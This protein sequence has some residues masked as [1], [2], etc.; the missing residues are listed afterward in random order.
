MKN[1]SAMVVTTAAGETAVFT[2]KGFF[3]GV[4]ITSNLTNDVT[5]LVED[6]TTE[7]VTYRLPGTSDCDSFPLPRGIAITGGLNVTVTGTGAQ[8][9]VLYSV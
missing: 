9:T 8:A 3:D 5:V 7:K 1:P 4:I 6:G 2:G